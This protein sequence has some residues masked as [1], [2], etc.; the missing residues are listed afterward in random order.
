MFLVEIKRLV[1]FAFRRHVVAAIFFY[2][3]R[4]ANPTARSR[5]EVKKNSFYMP[6]TIRF[7]S[8]RCY[9]ID[10]ITLNFGP[11]FFFTYLL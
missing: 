8:H 10:V 6:V 5:N 1:L 2:F 11:L 4:H 9:N 3:K 7:W